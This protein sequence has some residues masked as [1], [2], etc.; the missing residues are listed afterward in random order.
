MIE[1]RL[2]IGIITPTYERSELLQRLHLSLVDD[3][4]TFDWRH[5]VVNDGSRSDYSAVVEHCIE[6]SGRFQYAEIPNSGPLIA[7]NTAIDE[8][9][10][11][12]CTH[13]VFIDDDDA[14]L[15]GAINSL[16]ERVQQNP[17]TSWVLFPSRKNPPDP[18]PW[19]T[20]PTKMSWF[21][22]IVLA[23][24]LGSDNVIM[25]SAGAIGRSRFTARGRNQ[26]EWLFLLDVAMRHDDVLV[27]PEAIIKK[28]YHADGLTAEAGNRTA[29]VDQVLNG[30]ER[31]IRYWMMRPAYPKLF[32][33]A[34]ALIGLAPFRLI[35]AKLRAQ[36]VKK[37]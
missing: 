30:L 20:A 24:R 32:L 14:A 33:R 12:G 36:I 4:C 26:R 2:R 31:A 15:N 37:V 9:I 5:Y 11:D 27:C 22:D 8:A 35:R 17:R 7:R 29:N 34:L 18:Q 13:L 19:P 21:D 1:Q 16:G 23:R 10:A 28:E 25:M 3:R 6:T